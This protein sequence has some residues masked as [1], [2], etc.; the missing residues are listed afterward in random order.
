[1]RCSRHLTLFVS[2]VWVRGAGFGNYKFFVL[3]LFWTSVMGLFVAAALSPAVV[4][5]SLETGSVHHM[6]TF[7]MGLVF[8]LA[9]AAFFVSHWKLMAANQTTLES[10][11]NSGPITITYGWD[12]GSTLANVKQVLGNNWLL[13]F[14]PVATSTG[15]GISWPQRGESDADAETDRLMGAATSSDGIGASTAV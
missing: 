2:C 5:F 7:I 11:G 12:L 3:F 15:D 14:V 4:K 10:L 9:L 1:M 13:W 6:V 8:G